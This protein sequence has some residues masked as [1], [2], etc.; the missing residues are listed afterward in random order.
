MVVNL[1]KLIITGIIDGPLT[2]GLPKAIELYALDDIADLSAYGIGSANNGGGTDGQEF[3]M[4]GSAAAGSF[5]TIA[6]DSIEFTNYFGQG[7]T[8]ISGSANI[9]GDDA[10]ELFFNGAV[11]DTFGEISVDGSGQAWEYTDGWT[12]RKIGSAPGGRN[13]QLSEWSFS[14]ANAV[15]GCTDNGSC[16]SIFPFETFAVNN[17]PQPTSGPTTSKVSDSSNSSLEI[18]RSC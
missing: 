3:T 18:F 1:S 2:G 4:T 17:T 5:I 13:F 14:G 10:I 15:D 7:P 6:S 8:F 9:N 11:V 16:G 12:Y